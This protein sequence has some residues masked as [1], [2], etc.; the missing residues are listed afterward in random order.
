MPDAANPP[1]RPPADAS[2]A[3]DGAVEDS[4]LGIADNGPPMPR[5]AEALRRAIPVLEG[6]YVDRLRRGVPHAADMSE[7]DLRDDVGLVLGACAD[8]LEVPAA[9]S[10]V[11]RLAPMHG[12]A[13][14]AQGFKLSAV[15]RDNWEK[16]QLVAEALVRELGRDLSAGEL[17]RVQQVLRVMDGRNVCTYARQQ[18]RQLR[19]LAEARGDHLAMMAHDLRN[20]LNG[21]L[22]SLA[23]ARSAVAGAAGAADA[24]V[25]EDIADAERMVRGTVGTMGRL[26]ES[27]QRHSGAADSVLED[28]PLG[29]LLRSIARAS[30][31]AIEADGGASPREGAVEVDC[32]DKLTAHTDLELLSTIMLN[33][34]GN[35]LKY[36]GDAAIRVSVTREKQDAGDA[37]RIDVADGGPGIPADQLP[38]LFDRYSRGA[39]EPGEPGKPGGPPAQGGGLGLGLYICRRAADAL[40]AELSAASPPGGGATFT[41]RLPPRKPSPES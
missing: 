20:T 7:R 40:G 6:N 28:V 1:P 27:E 21:T 37:V 32:P 18:E 30:H 14:F 36:A 16:N 17:W 41:L 35:A 34:L 15:V 3:E 13:R 8:A 5:L 24:E 11:Y 12:V 2:A 25:L 4:L 39:G 10:E 23:A 9:I 19:L 33:L 29:P 26:L 22:L 38:H 31:R